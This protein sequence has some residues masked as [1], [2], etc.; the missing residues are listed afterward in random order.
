MATRS[1]YEVSIPALMQIYGGLVP[2][3][4]ADLVTCWCKCPRAWERRPLRIVATAGGLHPCLQPGGGVSLKVQ[5]GLR[6]GEWENLGAP[7]HCHRRS[8]MD[9]RIFQYGERARDLVWRSGCHELLAT[10]T[11]VQ[12]GIIIWINI[13]VLNNIDPFFL[14][15]I[16]FY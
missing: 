15:F 12:Y 7:L 9:T 8:R 14:I 13:Y 6:I 1:H 16:Y 4:K 2:G 3:P 11:A 5:S 10:P